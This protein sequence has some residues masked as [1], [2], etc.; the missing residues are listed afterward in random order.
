MFLGV[1]S[2]VH[3]TGTKR[4]RAARRFVDENAGDWASAYAPEPSRSQD[5]PFNGFLERVVDVCGF[6]RVAREVVLRS[7]FWR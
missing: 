3:A 6:S 5:S 1:G 7:R 2:V 4:C